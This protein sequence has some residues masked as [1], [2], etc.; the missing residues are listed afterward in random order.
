MKPEHVLTPTNEL[1]P[2][3]VLKEK[4]V[5]IRRELLRKIGVLKM[6]SKGI[7]VDTIGDYELIDMSPVF[8]GIN[9][10]PHLLMR[11]PSLP[12]TFHLEGVAPQ[13]HTIEQAI[14]WRAGNINIRWT[15]A[16]L[17]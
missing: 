9:Y 15:P 11:N 10:A 3:T 8:T 16:M 1:S 7:V 6:K 17:S 4:S 2:E 5:D 12:D 14:N 13:C